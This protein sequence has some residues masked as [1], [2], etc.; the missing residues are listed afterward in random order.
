MAHPKL[1]ASWEGFA[2]DQTIRL[3]RADR[4]AYF[5]RTHAGAELDLLVLRGG[6]RYGFE[7]K[8][9]D[10]PAPT[11]SM[12]IALADLGIEH[13]SV[14]YPGD[15]AYALDTRISVLPLADLPQLAAT[16]R[17]R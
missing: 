10:A 11:R 13:I 8:Y 17:W 7:F 6:T 2:L 16:R 14:V 4:D 15:R 5:Y 3:L 12:H 9:G 1:A